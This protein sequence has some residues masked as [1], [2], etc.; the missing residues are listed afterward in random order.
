MSDT[1]LFLPEGQPI[2][3]SMPMPKDENVFGDIFGGWIM[4]HVDIAG[5]IT[6]MRRTRGRIATV[7]V[8]SF[9]FKQPVS[10]GD[11][12]S[13]YTKVLSVGKTSLTISVEV[14]AERYAQEP[15]VVKVTEATLTYVAINDAGNKRDVPPEN[16]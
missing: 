6:A 10:S 3:R 1:P 8:N 5:G 16:A 2:L 14:F 11:V 13:F 15:V 12:V 7:A 4:A 9:Q